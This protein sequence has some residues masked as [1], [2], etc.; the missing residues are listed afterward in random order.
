[1][2]KITEA[3]G[4][5]NGVIEVPMGQAVTADMIDK[6]LATGQYDAVTLVH[7]E[8]STGIMHSL[9]EYAEVLKKYPDVISIVDAVSSM[10]GAKIEFD[11][12]GL[13]VVLAGTQK[14]F[15][16]P[17]G[18][19]VCAV[20]DK[21]MEK[22]KTV[23]NRGIYFDFLDMDSKYG[24]S[25]TPSTPAISLIQA[26]NKQMDDILAEGLENRWAR[27]K[28]MAAYVQ[29]WAREYWALFSDENYL[30]ST[31]SNITNT[32]GVSIKD[33]NTELAKR[34]AMLS[35]GYGDLKE[36]CFRIGHMGDHTIDDMR[37]LTTQ[38]EEI[39]GL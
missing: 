35:N 2:R 13:D 34:G 30:S 21:A 9:E 37:W 23:P 16:L 6:E 15:A 38:V 28:E 19:A 8:T 4:K 5:E 39:L 14:C 29:D 32:R 10:A 3:N 22:A 11:K 36:K 24:K 18:L 7:N 20:S 27:H 31:V 25:Q 12:L 33:L 17:P 26:L 1:M